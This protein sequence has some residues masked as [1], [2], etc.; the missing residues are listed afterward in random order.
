MGNS[1]D[2]RTNQTVLAFAARVEKADVVGVQEVVPTY[3]SVTVYFDALTISAEDLAARLRTLLSRPLSPT[4]QRGSVHAIPVLYGGSTGPDLDDVAHTAGLTP[5]QVIELHCSVLYHV[6]MLGFSPGFPYLGTLP[7]ALVMPRL[8][9]PRKRVAAGSI[10]LAGGQTG[11]YPQES[12]GGWRIIGRT[13]VR[14]FSMTRTKPFLL[15]AGDQ[16]RFVS[17]DDSEFHELS[18]DSV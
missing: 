12:P 11:I 3:R 10:G 9:T 4:R 13:P 15:Q 1:I 14:L 8:A 5:R 6:Y 17:I 16:V 2:I 7:A 18:E